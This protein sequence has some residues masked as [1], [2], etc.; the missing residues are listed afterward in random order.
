MTTALSTESPQLKN[1]KSLVQ[2]GTLEEFMRFIKPALEELRPYIEQRLSLLAESGEI[3]RGR[4]SVD[5]IVD[6]VFVHAYDA[7]EDKS[8]FLHV[9]QWLR[10]LTDE[11]IAHLIKMSTVKL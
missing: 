10:A 3:T 8:P 1:N 6:E 5:T 9:E 2:R 4:Y 7:H 11:V